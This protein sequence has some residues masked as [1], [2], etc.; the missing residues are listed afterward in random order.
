MIYTAIEVWNHLNNIPHGFIN[1]TYWEPQGLPLLSLD[2][3]SWDDH[4]LVPWTGP[5]PVWIELT[6]NNIDANGHPFHL[7]SFCFLSFS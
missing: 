5:E 2:R 1:H 7:V 4:Q 6:I 3:E